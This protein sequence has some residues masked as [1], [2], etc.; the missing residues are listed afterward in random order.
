MAER[1]RLSLRAGGSCT[2]TLQWPVS[3]PPPNKLDAPDQASGPAPAA[4]VALQRPLAAPRLQWSV[5]VLDGR[6]VDLEVSATVHAAAPE[7]CGGEGARQASEVCCPVVLERQAR[8][9]HFLGCLDPAGSAADRRRLRMP[10]TCFCPQVEAVVFRFSNAF[11]WLSSK[12]VELIT[13]V[14]W[15]KFAALAADP[16]VGPKLVEETAEVWGEYVEHEEYEEYEE[17]WDGEEDWQIEPEAGDEVPKASAP[18]VTCTRAWG[19]RR[20]CLP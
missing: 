15:P 10:A 16:A 17:E 19:A 7:P 1:V 20:A 3:P 8:G 13:L 11:S 6:E 18:T 12:E 9:D 5:V 4:D 14:E 2:H